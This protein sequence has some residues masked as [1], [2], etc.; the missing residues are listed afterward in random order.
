MVKILESK[1]VDVVEDPEPESEV[2]DKLEPEPEVTEL[3]LQ[4]E[5][6]LRLT[7]AVEIL[8]ETL[9]DLP[10]EHIMEP[11]PSLIVMGTSLSWRSPDE[12][13]PL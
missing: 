4:E 9:V 10:V 8:I 2:D 13:D 1:A 5:I 6:F 11:M 3:S 12:Y 7:E